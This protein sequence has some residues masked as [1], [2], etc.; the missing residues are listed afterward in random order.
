MGPAVNSL[1][2][3]LQLIDAGMNVAR[4]NFSH[5]T[6]AEHLETIEILKKARAMRKVPLAILLDTKGPEIRVGKVDGG[7]V[8]VEAG[9]RVSLAGLHVTPQIAI[10]AVQVG[11]SVLFDDGY[12]MAKVVEKK[13]GDALVE[14]QNEGAIKSGKGVNMPDTRLNLPAMTENDVA[15]IAF[16]CAHDIDM[17]AASFIRSADHIHE[18]RK[19]LAQH[20]RPDILLHAK[21]ENREGVNNF[22]S[23]LQ[24]ADGIMVARGDLGVELPLRQVPVL[25]KM[26]IRKCNAAC[27]P[28]FTATQMLESMINNPR[29]TRAEV[30]DV[31]NAI[32]DSTSAV[33]LSGETAV[34]HH[35]VETVAMMQSIIAE[36]ESDFNYRHFFDHCR[37][38]EIGDV[39]TA[40]ALSSIK[41]AYSAG[42]KAIFAFTCSGSTARL[43]S[44]YRPKM[45]IIAFTS[46]EKVYHQLAS[47]W[48]VIPIPPN[49]AHTAHEAMT[50]TK[51]FALKHGLIQHGD[52]VVVTAGVPFGIPGTTNMMI[53][54]K[55]A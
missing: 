7:Q 41:M 3:I 33:M 18:I 53:I 23:I 20:K 49:S 25:Q 52:L 34:G 45:P 17:I 48:G 21:I 9:Q 19:L 8:P 40:V 47:N 43:L 30:S 42:A 24:A 2:K 11:D 32:Y 16:G 6:H 22:D 4:L 26:M 54:E 55:I 51:A 38:T 44:S 37:E 27:K 36:A 12:I 29:P 46:N 39:A 50:I 31:A 28:V 13:R 5:R 10:D 1:E 15:D 14:I 35:P